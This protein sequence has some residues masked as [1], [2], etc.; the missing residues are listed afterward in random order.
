MKAETK[1]WNFGIVDD[2]KCIWSIH[3]SYDSALKE[4]NEKGWGNPEKH[5]VKIT[6]LE[7]KNITNSP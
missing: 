1:Y 4:L 6:K 5:I 7:Y 3:P 2:D